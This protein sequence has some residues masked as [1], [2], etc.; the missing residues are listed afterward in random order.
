M[1]CRFPIE[2]GDRDLQSQRRDTSACGHNTHNSLIIALW[3]L[4]HDGHG[5]FGEVEIHGFRLP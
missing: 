3:A 4:I 5:V 1:C 2:N